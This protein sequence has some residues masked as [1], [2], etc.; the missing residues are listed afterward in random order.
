[1]RQRTGQ[2]AA[3]FGQGLAMIWRDLVPRTFRVRS[4]LFR[5]CSMQ[6]VAKEGFTER[7]SLDG[8]R[9]SEFFG[10]VMARPFVFGKE[11][12]RRRRRSEPAKRD[13]SKWEEVEF[14]KLE[15]YFRPL[16]STFRC[17]LREGWIAFRVV[18]RRIWVLA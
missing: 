4:G 1:M 18:S 11:E 12:A 13:R 5:V 17:F 10:F 3:T 14:H 16:S 15:L 2:D 7:R 8:A 9:F 6:C